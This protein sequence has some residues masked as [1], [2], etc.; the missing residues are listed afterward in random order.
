MALA[1][2]VGESEEFISLRDYRQGDPPRRVHWRSWA[3][4]GRLIVKEHQDEFFVRHALVLDTFARPDQN[5]AFEESVSVAASFACAIS[6][7]ESLLDLMFIGPRAVSFTMGRGLAHTEQALEILA[8]VQPCHDKPFRSLY[9][10]V[11]R[12]ATTL[13][14]CICILLDWDVARRELVQHIR[15]LNVPLLV[16]V[17]AEGN[18]L[19]RIRNS[20]TESTEPFHLLD[21]NRVAEGLAALQ[22]VS[23]Q[24][25]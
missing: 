10:L 18:Q 22:T 2:S 14:G 17:I 8:S 24:S 12:H 5:D 25:I 16:L 6:T 20:L 19:T 23:L 3:K 1:S 4:T 21:V 15:M 7:Q 11:T 9:E 13:S